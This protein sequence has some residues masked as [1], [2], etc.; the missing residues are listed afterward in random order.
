MAV[1][2]GSAF[3]LF[4]ETG[5]HAGTVQRLSP[6]MH[7]LGSEL[8]ADI[9]LS[10]LDVK[11]IHLIIELDHRGLRLE[12]LQGA[13]AIDGEGSDLEPGGERHLPFPA[14][15]S[16]GSIT[17]KVA[18]PT[19]RV[20]TRRRVRAAALLTGT[21]LLALVGFQVIDP[22]GR[23]AS[24]EPVSP[25]AA[26]KL[27]GEPEIDDGLATP[28][29]PGITAKKA[30]D[31]EPPE[32]DQLVKTVPEVT[33]DDAAAALRA[34]LEADGLRHIEVKTAVDRLLVRGEAEPE[35]MADWRTIRVWFDSTFGQDV[36][37]VAA[38]DPVENRKPPALAIEAVWSGD[39]PYLIAGGK[40]FF[41]GAAIG[42]GWTI[43]RIDAVEITFR[44]GNRTFSLTL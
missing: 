10:D 15:F 20:Q 38:V 17:I 37:L 19:D 12:P 39:D 41:L 23:A 40:R 22:V 25:L 32:N 28:G 31:T 11:A 35:R 36:L 2:S 21:A 14:A 7:T 13:I 4:V 29:T 27:A 6:G 26:A 5:L 33:L 43:E 3:T 18:A 30:S 1:T 44:R 16:I 34:R 24:D 8:D 9:V 42:D